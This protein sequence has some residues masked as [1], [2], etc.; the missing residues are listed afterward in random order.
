MKATDKNKSIPTVPD[1]SWE[2]TPPR[3]GFKNPGTSTAD[4]QN[5]GY[6]S[7]APLPNSEEEERPREH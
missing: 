4:L 3:Q 5:D 2:A 7:A 1:G 6:P